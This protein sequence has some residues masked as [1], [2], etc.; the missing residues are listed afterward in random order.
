VEVQGLTLARILQT[1][2]VSATVFEQETPTNSH[3]QGGS[4][5]LHPE[6]GL[7]ALRTTNLFDQFK[8]FARYEGQQMRMIDKDGIIH[9]D[10]QG[11]MGP[12]PADEAGLDKGRP[13]IDRFASANFSPAQ[14]DMIYPSPFQN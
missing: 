3:S 14:L 2:G 12:P 4:L 7:K 10:K 5:D 8:K 13:E 9:L 6:S 1:H 11:P